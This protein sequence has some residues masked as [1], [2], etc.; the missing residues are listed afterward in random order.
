MNELLSCG[1]V[2]VSISVIPIRFSFSTVLCY[3]TRERI[4][5]FEIFIDHHFYVLIFTIYFHSQAKPV[6][7]SRNH[8]PFGVLNGNERNGNLLFSPLLAGGEIRCCYNFRIVVRNFF[9][10]AH[11]WLL[12]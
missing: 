9:I 10:S 6:I 2:A 8:L 5:P 12:C 1:R 7:H 3:P 4:F 11:S